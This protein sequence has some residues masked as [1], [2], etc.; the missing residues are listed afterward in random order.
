MAR[1]QSLEEPTPLELTV[2]DGSG[3]QRAERL[4]IDQEGFAATVVKALAAPVESIRVRQGERVLAEGR[5][6][7]SRVEPWR[8]VPRLPLAWGRSEGSGSIRVVPLDG[9]LL[10]GIPGRLLIGVGPDGAGGAP[11]AAELESDSLRFGD[12][13]TS[14]LKILLGATPIIRATALDPSG[15]I[16][17]HVTEPAGQSSGY[18]GRLRT[19]MAGILAEWQKDRWLLKSLVA[20]DRVYYLEFDA[21]GPTKLG[22]EGLRR[23]PGG[24][25]QGEVVPSVARAEGGSWLLVGPDP[26]LD[27]EASVAW[28]RVLDPRQ[29]EPTVSL[30]FPVLLDGRRA[31][32]R[33][34]ARELQHHWRVIWGWGGAVGL[35]LLYCVWKTAWA[36]G[37]RPVPGSDEDMSRLPLRGPSLGLLIVTSLLLLGAVASLMVWGWARLGG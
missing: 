2:T 36:G 22:T 35:L 15:A 19:Q 12:E 1:V 30:H 25:W 31:A 18:S 32:E 4:L 13:P 24:L 20:R 37:S 28:P 11:M 10:V 16:T 9:L 26:E 34:W 17:V 23:T 29:A 6:D 7:R 27:G 33:T 21:N 5:L 8:V 3:N 14:Q